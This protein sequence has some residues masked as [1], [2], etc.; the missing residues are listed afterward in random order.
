VTTS[1]DESRVGPAP[2]ELDHVEET[3]LGGLV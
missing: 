2:G 1:V 3:P